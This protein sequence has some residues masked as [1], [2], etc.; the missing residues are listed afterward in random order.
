[1]IVSETMLW[2]GTVFSL[3]VPCIAWIYFLSSSTFWL[4]LLIECLVLLSSSTK[5]SFSVRVFSSLSAR[6]LDIASNFYLSWTVSSS[7]TICFLRLLS[8]ISF[9]LCDYFLS[10]RKSFNSA[11][12]SLTF[13]CS[14]FLM[15]SIFL[16]SWC[17]CYCSSSA[18]SLCWWSKL[19]YLCRSCIYFLSL[20]LTAWVESCRILAFDILAENS[21]RILF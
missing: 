2:T 19:Y 9:L 6:S 10:A 20:A 12:S 1:M 7:R 11:V 13:S 16:Y 14:F 3:I 21:L 18:L 17:W 4:Y 5:A 8:L 15:F